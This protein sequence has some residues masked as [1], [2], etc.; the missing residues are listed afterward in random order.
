M[1]WF[2]FSAR[3]NDTRKQATAGERIE[4]LYWA[5]LI[6]TGNV[7]SARESIIDAGGLAKTSSY[8]FRDWLIR[9]GRSATT[10]VAVKAVRASIHQ[11]AAQ[12]RDRTCSHHAHEP[13]SS[14]EVQKLCAVDAYVVIEQLDVL[15]R[16][17][18]VLYGCHHAS[19]SQCVLLLDVPSESIVGAYC[20]ALQWYYEF[21]AQ[22][23][24]VRR[25]ESSRLH[26]VRYDA[27]GIP[28]WDRVRPL[29]QLTERG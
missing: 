5:A 29:T 2:G 1:N 25:S 9:W 16:A 27:N 17:A 23:E 24:T 7:Q 19:L 14:A 10:R 26:L 18:L 15:A 8:E 4:S 3:Q 6:I 12:F 22:T 28:V 11:T 20:R 21:A 13:L